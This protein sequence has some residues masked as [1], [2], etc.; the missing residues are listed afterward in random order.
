MSLG[1]IASPAPPIGAVLGIASVTG[2]VVAVVA[3]K[4]FE[5]A[6]LLLKD[7]IACSC[8]QKHLQARGSNHGFCADMLTNHLFYF[9][10]STCLT[11]VAMI[12]FKNGVWTSSH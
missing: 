9:I 5:Q 10:V 11:C 12:L 8:W 3:F 6:Q 7:T 4:G 2:V 1:L